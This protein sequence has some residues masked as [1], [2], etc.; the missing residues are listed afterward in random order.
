MKQSQSTIKNLSSFQQVD[1]LIVKNISPFVWFICSFVA[2]NTMSMLC[3]KNANADFIP[4]EPPNQTIGKSLCVCFRW[5][6]LR[7]HCWM[8]A[9]FAMCKFW[10][11]KIDPLSPSPLLFG[12]K[13]YGMKQYTFLFVANIATTKNN[14]SLRHIALVLIS[15]NQNQNHNMLQHA[16]VIVQVLRHKLHL[17]HSLSA[18][19]A[20]QQWV[21]ESRFST[22]LKIH[23]KFRFWPKT[24]IF[25]LFCSELYKDLECLPK[26]SF[27][28]VFFKYIFKYLFLLFPEFKLLH[29]IIMKMQKNN[30]ES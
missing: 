24:K 16:E 18:S 7:A 30:K 11:Y 28:S 15:Y 8:L 27:K 6:V 12:I 25:V 22:T 3:S 4:L 14:T 21:I 17:T 19:S 10:F 13:R 2:W 26:Y 20:A 23:R 9:G 29:F 1:W 5:E